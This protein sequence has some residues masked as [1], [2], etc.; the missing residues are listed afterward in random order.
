[1]KK[2]YKK[3]INKLHFLSLFLARFVCI[4]VSYSY[5][6]NRNNFF[7]RYINDII[8]PRI[9]NT[10]MCLVFLGL[11]LS[12]FANAQGWEKSYDFNNQNGDEE[13]NAIIQT[14]DQGYVVVGRTDG[15]SGSTGIQVYVLRL[16][17]DGTIIWNE[18]VGNEDA[19]TNEIGHAVVEDD[20][21]SLV[22][23]G[24][25]NLGGE[26]DGKD[27]FL[28]KLDRFGNELWRKFYGTDGDDIGL[29][30]NKTSDGGFIITG[31]SDND[32]YI[33]KT[34]SEGDAEWEV[35]GLDGLEDAV[36]HDVIETPEGD[37][38]ITGSVG[39][40]NASNVLVL[41]I[42][43]VG[44]YL[45]DS[46]FGG[47][48]NDIAYK[49][50]QAN[51]G[52][53][54]IAG[55]KGNNSNFYC[56]KIENTLTDFDLKWAQ[57]YGLDG[58][59]EE[60]KSIVQMRDGNFALAGLS[61]F[62]NDDLLQASVL[63]IDGVDGDS[64]SIRHYGNTGLDAANDIL[65]TPKGEFVVTGFT[66]DPMSFFPQDVLLVKSKAVYPSTFSNHI[67]G[68]VFYDLN[69]NCTDD[70]ISEQ[71]IKQW[72]VKAV[73]DSETYYDATDEFGNYDISV[74][75]GT[76]EVSVVRPN[77]YWQA[78][79]QPVVNANF[80]ALYDTLVRDFAIYPETVCTDLEVD[81]STTFVRAC[82]EATYTVNYCNHGTILAEDVDVSLILS[83]N[84]SFISV[85]GPPLASVIDS[86]YLFEVGNLGVGACG[87]F[88]IT[89]EADCDALLSETHCIKAEIS[90]DDLNCLP[91]SPT[92]DGS[93]VQVNGYCDGDSVRF[94]IQNTGNLPM[95]Q[96]LNYIITEDIIMGLQ[97]PDGPL[98][99]AGETL[100]EAFAA[101]GSTYRLIAR[102]S[103]G[104]PGNSISPSIAIEGCVA[105]GGTDYSTG[106]HTQFPEDDRDHFLATDCQE[107]IPSS[108]DSQVKRGYP[109]GYGDS[110]KIANTTDLKYHIKFQNIGTDTA[111]RVVI[112]DT[113]SPLLDPQTVRPGAS[114]HDYEFEVY[115]NGILKFTFNNIM[116]IDSSTNADASHG[117]IKYRITQKPGNLE[118]SIIKN[119]AA[120]FFDYL[121]PLETDSVCHLVAGME[122]TDFIITSNHNIYIPQTEIKIYPNPISQFATFELESASIQPPLDF[123]IFDVAGKPVRSE[124]F[125]NTTFTFNRGDLPAGM[126]FYQ[127]SSRN[128]LISTGKII[129][130]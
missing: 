72:I 70:G 123:K 41:K 81:V 124:R 126:Y 90:P 6:N 128:Q 36:G 37:F 93:S 69:N 105:G 57:E 78:P 95:T 116:L 129:A 15:E 80:P 73:G 59:S 104:H 26:F 77:E 56:I 111:I 35:F 38:I 11:L 8:K 85:Q 23:V 110:L 118:G 24:E 53:Y 127:I 87:S 1:M 115:D 106:Y 112:R 19:P 113:I 101:N 96:P 21:Q 94:Q 33:L 76:Y 13:A 107:N 102:Q 49:I 32:L 42:N 82:E 34:D 61:D 16:D 108:F 39:D 51:D 119:G 62:E 71:G 58:T 28:F 27:V 25:T 48:S 14:I 100:E 89:V 52:D 60:A 103:E 122:W 55:K 91:P 130:K 67:V 5:T 88:T 18:A 12:L 75:T 99:A 7:M 83:N 92:W 43:N 97:E 65:M 63:I 40:N 3:L 86:L 45:T 20:D 54:V 2:H 46:T 22:I 4:F 66:T 31:S 17:V 68:N 47:T 120:I 125:Y 50:I 109:K 10:R 79:C 29:G 30:I 117:F 114:S 9:R 84:L 74:G 98:L 44:Q 121:T 64:I